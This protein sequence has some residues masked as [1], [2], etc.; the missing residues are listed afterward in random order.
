MFVTILLYYYISIKFILCHPSMTVYD[1]TTEMAGLPFLNT[2]S[3][4]A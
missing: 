1:L 4:T 2:V 3:T